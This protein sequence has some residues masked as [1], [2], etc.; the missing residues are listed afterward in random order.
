MARKTV[1]KISGRS[2]RGRT[3][4]PAW[5]YRRLTNAALFVPMVLLFVQ[6]AVAQT[7]PGGAA[8]SQNSQPAAAS[9]SGLPDYSADPK[10]FPHVI[11]SYRQ[12]RIPPADLNNTESLSEMIHDGKIELSLSQ[13]AAAVVE[14]NL[15]LAEDRYNNYFAQADL[16]RTKSG[17]AARGVSAANIGIPPA[18]SSGAIGAGV[19]DR[20]RTVRRCWQRG[21]HFRLGEKPH[22]RAPRRLRSHISVQF[23]LGSHREPSE[24][25]GCRRLS[26]RHHELCFLRFRLSASLSYRNQLSAW[27]SPM[28]AK[29][30]RSS[31]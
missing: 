28:N 20:G 1:L 9:Q 25:L 4:W 8:Q 14:N 10:W 7:P 29:K 2:G 13:F 24:H 6:G 31:R 26:R 21:S 30:A 19:G 17:Q 15:A 27:T 16:L 11:S 3:R 5:R 22:P 12:Q 23:Q 18:L